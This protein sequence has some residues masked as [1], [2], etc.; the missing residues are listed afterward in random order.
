MSAGCLL[1]T[2]MR[3]AIGASGVISFKMGKLYD[4]C[5]RIAVVERHSI[6]LES[7]GLPESGVYTLFNQPCHG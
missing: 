2:V 7:R 5:A 1:E 4:L 6:C 3:V